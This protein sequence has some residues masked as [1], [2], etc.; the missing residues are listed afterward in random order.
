MDLA[1]VGKG[2]KDKPATQKLLHNGNPHLQVMFIDA[3]TLVAT[4][5][6]KVPFVYK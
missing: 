5:Y 4:G 1:G 6:D 3:D 2:S